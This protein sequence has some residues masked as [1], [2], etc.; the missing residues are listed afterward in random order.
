MKVAVVGGAALLGMDFTRV[1]DT[2]IATTEQYIA[3]QV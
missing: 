2:T 1:R 3:E